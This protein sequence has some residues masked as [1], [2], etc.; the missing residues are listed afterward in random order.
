M[1][2]QLY[3]AIGTNARTHM[4]CQ[5]VLAGNMAHRV[6]TI[7]P[8]MSG[9]IQRGIVGPTT[10]RVVSNIVRTIAYMYKRTV[11]LPR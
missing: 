10:S 7:V 8:W 9:G 6:S 2:T 3:R 5:Y 4:A 1:T 11:Q